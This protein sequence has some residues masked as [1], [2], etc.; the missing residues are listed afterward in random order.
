[1]PK[2]D[3][4]FSMPLRVRWAEVDQQGVVFFGNY[5]EYFDLAMTEYMRAIGWDYPAGFLKNGTDLHVVKAE[6]DYHDGARFDDPLEIHCRVSRLGRS[7]LTFSFEIYREGDGHL[8]TSGQLTYVN[9][10]QEKKKSEA[11]PERFVELVRSREGTA[12][13]AAT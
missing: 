1:M 4:N 10:H 13:P 2:S 9:V 8:I 11:L 5:L 12:L 7:S 6:C 3:F